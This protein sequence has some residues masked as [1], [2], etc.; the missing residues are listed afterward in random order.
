VELVQEGVHI[1]VRRHARERPR[2][3]PLLRDDVV[4]ISSLI[5]LIL[6]NAILHALQT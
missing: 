4:R 6:V 5:V 1:L 3:R 2:D